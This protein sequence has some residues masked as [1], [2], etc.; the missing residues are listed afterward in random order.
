[1]PPL[2]VSLVLIVVLVVL[3]SGCWDIV[4]T[5]C[6]SPLLGRRVLPWVLLRLRTAQSLFR[7]F[8]RSFSKSQ[9]LAWISQAFCSRFTKIMPII[10]WFLFEIFLGPIFSTILS[11]RTQIILRLKQILSLASKIS[12]WDLILLLLARCMHKY[13]TGP[14]LVRTVHCIII[15]QCSTST[16]IYQYV[17]VVVGSSTW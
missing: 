2:G 17:V 4:C 3:H 14:V 11:P 6:P 9:C 7:P 12:L 8:S 16:S 5:R 10:I 13:C 1:M 15:A